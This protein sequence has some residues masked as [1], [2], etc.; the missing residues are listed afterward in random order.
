MKFLSGVGGNV[1]RYLHH[2]LSEQ[3]YRSLSTTAK[4]NL[5]QKQFFSWNGDVDV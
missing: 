4:K 5:N 2:L 3:Y 1:I